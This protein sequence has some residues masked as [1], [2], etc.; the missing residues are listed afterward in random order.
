MIGL[1]Q[2]Y[3]SSSSAFMVQQHPT[4]LR[5]KEH[6]MVWHNE[7][8]TTLTNNQADITHENSGQGRFQHKSISST[9]MFIIKP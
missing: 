8:Q 7:Y 4:M 2:Q 1:K 6:T 3:A 5:E 9:S